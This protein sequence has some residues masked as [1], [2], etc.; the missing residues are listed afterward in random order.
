MLL[1]SIRYAPLILLFLISSCIPQNKLTYFQHAPPSDEKQ[2]VNRLE[3]LLQPGDILHV[4]ILAS[5]PE[6]YDV[7][8]PDMT[9]RINVR[10]GDTGDPALYLY[11]YTIDLEG[12]IH[13]PVMGSVKMAGLNLE[14]AQQA[15]HDQ[16]KKYLVDA[17][18]TAKLINF[19]V[20]VLGE[21]RR[22][23]RFYVYDHGFTLMDALAQ[24]GDLT[25]YG[26]RNV[27][28]IRNTPNGLFFGQL[29]ITKSQ[30]VS[31]ELFYLQPNDLVYVEPL[32]AKRFGFDQFPFG[33]IFSSIST[34]LLLI[35][36]L[37]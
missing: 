29:D 4:S 24:A 37:R 5:D 32:R 18:V 7:F 19:S 35:N 31:D 10:P 8:N 15:I 25:N 23:G 12:D 13:L 28:V 36:F 30:A 9:R 21:V 20:T 3:Y 27:H 2:P 16:A 6:M 1:Q 22:P 14:Q 34:S 33:V 11:G 26:S 17:T